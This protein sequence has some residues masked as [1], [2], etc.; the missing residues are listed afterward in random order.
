[1]GEQSPVSKEK[2]DRTINLDRGNIGLLWLFCMSLF[3]CSSASVFGKLCS[4]QNTPGALC[5][6]T[7]Y[8][9]CSPALTVDAPLIRHPSRAGWTCWVCSLR[10]PYFFFSD[11]RCTTVSLPSVS[12]TDAVRILHWYSSI[13]LTSLLCR[14]ECETWPACCFNIMTTTDVSYVGVLDSTRVIT[15][16]VFQA[17]SWMPQ[18]IG[19]MGS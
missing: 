15:D 10:T 16:C 17:I 19:W 1:M 7:V 11:R 5:W 12:V 4:R 9:V 6:N 18:Q 8:C 14:G 2:Q 13:L 3:V